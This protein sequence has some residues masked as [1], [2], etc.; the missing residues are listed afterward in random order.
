MSQFKNHQS[1][2]HGLPH[3]ALIYHIL[4]ANY[5]TNAQNSTLHTAVDEN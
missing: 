5:C 2:N 4:N 3:P 1:I